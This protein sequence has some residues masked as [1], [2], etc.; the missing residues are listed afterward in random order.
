MPMWLLAAYMKAPANMR[1]IADV[2]VL[3]GQTALA[4][5]RPGQIGEALMLIEQDHHLIHG[6]QGVQQL[7]RPS[8][9]CRR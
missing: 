1:M 9:R 4:L 5:P 8:P 3:G 7:G 2:Q 6:V